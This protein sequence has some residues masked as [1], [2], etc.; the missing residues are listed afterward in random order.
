MF[1]T[2]ALQNASIKTVLCKVTA[3]NGKP[4]FEQL[5]K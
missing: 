5:K 1:G 4:H 2:E 3:G